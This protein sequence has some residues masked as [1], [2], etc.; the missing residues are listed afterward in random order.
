MLGY[1]AVAPHYPISFPRVLRDAGYFTVSIGK[2][3]F[4]WN[5]TSDS[6]IAHGYDRTDLYDGLGLRT[7]TGPR[8]WK[9]EY[10]DYDRWFANATGG[11]DPQATLDDPSRGYDGWN[12]WHGKAYVYDETLHPTYWVHCR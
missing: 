9:G 7:S 4:G 2:D 6:G 10:D 5:D 8:H 12:G 1:G 3:H 11:K